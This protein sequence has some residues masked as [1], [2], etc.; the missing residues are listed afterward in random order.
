M[1]RRARRKRA[2]KRRAGLLREWEQVYNDAK[3]IT[4]LDSPP[5]EREMAGVNAAA[6][7]MDAKSRDCPQEAHMYREAA[8][9]FARERAAWFRD[10]YGAEATRRLGVLMAQQRSDQAFVEFALSPK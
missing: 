9:V 8:G 4:P 3:A 10:R 2:A 7:Y 5:E 6:G 1:T